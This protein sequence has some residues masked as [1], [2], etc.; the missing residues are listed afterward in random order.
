MPSQD[1]VV[2]NESLQWL[3]KSRSVGI[4]SEKHEDILL[5]KCIYIHQLK[6]LHVSR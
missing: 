3:G 6:Q 1:G 5:I 2:F 4:F